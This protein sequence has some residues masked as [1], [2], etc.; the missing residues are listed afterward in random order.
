MFVF[1]PR[2]CEDIDSVTV[3]VYIS[4]KPRDIGIYCGNKKPPMLMSTGNVLE[5]IYVRRSSST[6]PGRAFNAKYEFVTGMNVA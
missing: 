2:Q 4:G 3:I 6:M 1:S 5:V